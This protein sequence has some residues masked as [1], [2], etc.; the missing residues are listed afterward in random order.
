MK[1][2]KIIIVLG[3]FIIIT[4]ILVN[5]PNKFQVKERFD[6]PEKLISTFN[7]SLL[8]GYSQNINGEVTQ[9]LYD[10]ISN[11]KRLSDPNVRFNKII[12]K[13]EYK[14]SKKQK[15][16]ILKN[17]KNKANKIKNYKSPEE[18]IPYRFKADGINYFNYFD[19][20][21]D[22][23]KENLEPINIDFVVIKEN[24]SYVFDYIWIDFNSDEE[25]K[26]VG[27]YDVKS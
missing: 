20:N 19:G 27:E 4:S 2:S 25:N 26:V 24:G 23:I 6:T 5:N 1:K 9:T 21:S 17:Y 22:Y 11:R 10:A 7:N 13:S 18:A 15:E 14:L 3:A 12:L 8:L 16:D